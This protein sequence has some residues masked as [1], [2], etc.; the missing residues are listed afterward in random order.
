MS[1]DFNFEDYLEAEVLDQR[2]KVIGNLDCYWT[3]ETTDEALFLGVRTK[4]STEGV[5]V[6]PASLAE[7][8]ERES[9]VVL[10]MGENKV[11]KAPQLE[12]D[13]ELDPPF[14]RRVYNYF[15][16]SLP[17]KVHHL[18]IHRGS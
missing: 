3:D 18:H 7:A 14:E 9:C 13:A 8:N 12:C 2:G 15:E 5:S 16:L 17:E 4:P 6:V 1:L 10:S 11:S